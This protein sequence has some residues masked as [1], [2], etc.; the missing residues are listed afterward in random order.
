LLTAETFFRIKERF[1]EDN[2]KEVA[3]TVEG[4]LYGLGN[5]LSSTGPYPHVSDSSSTPEPQASSTPDST[6]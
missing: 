4:H 3:L 2:W 5:T 1:F 6:C